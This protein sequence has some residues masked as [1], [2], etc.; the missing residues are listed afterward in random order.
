MAHQPGHRQPTPQP[1]QKRASYSPYPPALLHGSV[2]KSLQYTER[3]HSLH[4]LPLHC[5]RVVVPRARPCVEPRCV[6]RIFSQASSILFMRIAA[7]MT[8]V[9]AAVLSGRRVTVAMSARLSPQRPLSD[10]AWTAFLL[11]L[12]S[13]EASVPHAGGT[14]VFRASKVPLMWTFDTLLHESEHF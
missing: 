8:S 10:Q 14:Q 2:W 11:F 12:I 5:S 4:S 13:P 9:A 7:S 6:G 1:R 3:I